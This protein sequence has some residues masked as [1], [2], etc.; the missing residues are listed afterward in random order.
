M[1]GLNFERGTYIRATDTPFVAP[2]DNHRSTQPSVSSTSTE[3]FSGGKLQRRM[4]VAGTKFFRLREPV[5]REDSRAILDLFK[6][7]GEVAP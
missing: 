7:T 1:S 4:K 6:P 5:P 2:K 3:I